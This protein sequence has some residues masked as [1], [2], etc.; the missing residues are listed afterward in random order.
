MYQYY[1]YAYV[2]SWHYDRESASGTH[3]ASKDCNYPAHPGAGGATGCTI[4]NNKASFGRAFNAD[5]GG[6]FAM[7]WTA[8][9]IATWMWKAETE[10]IKNVMDDLNTTN[11][12]DPSSAVWGKP[13]AKWQLGSWCPSSQFSNHSVTINLAYDIFISLYILSML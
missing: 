13:V 12:P 2:G 7:E 1:I 4:V 10:E 11:G 8:D 3:Y 6:L 5:G 9:H